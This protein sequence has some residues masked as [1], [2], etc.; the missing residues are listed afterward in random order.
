MME[1]GLWLVTHFLATAMIIKN[2]EWRGL[3][4]SFLVVGIG[5]LLALILNYNTPLVASILYIVENRWI[6]EAFI[7]LN[8]IIGYQFYARYRHTS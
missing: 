2:K 4:A 7:F 3:G 8:L 6:L 1:I 5:S